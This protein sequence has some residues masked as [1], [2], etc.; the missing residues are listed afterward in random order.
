MINEIFVSMR[1]VSVVVCVVVDT[2]YGVVLLLAQK[3]EE[4]L[5]KQ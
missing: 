5:S 3:K 1:R 2:E 4:L